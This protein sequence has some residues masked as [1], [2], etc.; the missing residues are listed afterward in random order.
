M[1]DE[2]YKKQLLTDLRSLWERTK[3]ELKEHQDT[4]K[5]E[6]CHLCWRGDHKKW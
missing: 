1:T 5:K 6:H 2:E 3:L 4:C